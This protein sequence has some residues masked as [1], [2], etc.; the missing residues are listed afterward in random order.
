MESVLQHLLLKRCSRSICGLCQ[1][2][3]V[4]RNWKT[5]KLGTVKISQPFC[6][7]QEYAGG[8]CVTPE[9]TDSDSCRYLLPSCYFWLQI[10]ENHQISS[11]GA[12]VL[13]LSW[14]LNWAPKKHARVLVSGCA[15]RGE[16]ERIMLKDQCSKWLPRS[17]SSQAPCN[18]GRGKTRSRVA[19]VMHS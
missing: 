13:S 18:K 14:A 10:P 4:Q 3:S 11:P 5:W 2:N 7:R 15:V 6:K 1:G 19:S 16:K 8:S 17:G 12:W 9:G